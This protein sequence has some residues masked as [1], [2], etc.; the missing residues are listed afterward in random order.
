MGRDQW[1]VE[2]TR[3]SPWGALALVLLTGLALVRNGPGLPPD[4]PRPAVAPSGRHP[5]SAGALA[6]G[7]S[8]RS[9][10]HP[11]AS[12]VVIPSLRVDAP[13]IETNSSGND[14]I[15]PPAPGEPGL[16]GWYR[17]GVAPGQPGTSVLV[18]R[19][20]ST[21]GRAVFH[22]VGSLRK[23]SRIEVS[24][25]D[26]TAAVFELYGVELLSRTRCPGPRVHGGT[27][28]AELRIISCGG[29]TADGHDRGTVVVLAR[30]VTSGRPSATGSRRAVTGGAAP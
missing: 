28:R 23:G 24:R 8:V 2:R 11:A 27:G 29:T 1:R 12:R 21:A 10:A 9:P 18:G 20:D 14:R 4:P 30:L 19:A 13:I 26:G 7:A 17:N 16:A 22:G 15:E 6:E 25:P 3:Y 5:G